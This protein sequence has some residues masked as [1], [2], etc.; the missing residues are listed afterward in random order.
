M[1]VQPCDPDQLA[2]P[3]WER[4]IGETTRAFD[5][6]TRYTEA[7][8][9]R[10]IAS[11][12]NDGEYPYDTVRDWAKR[13]RWRERAAGFDRWLA[14]RRR[15]T[16][17]DEYTEVGRRHARQAQAA[18]ELAL[19]PALVLLDRMR[20]DRTVLAELEVMPVADLYTMAMAGIRLLPH[21]Q[22]AEQSARGADPD[23]IATAVH[24]LDVEYDDDHLARVAATFAEIGLLPALPQPDPDPASEPEVIAS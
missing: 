24:I 15:Q 11:G 22:S 3:I 6:F 9:D 18:L 19:R 14:D 21:L 16:Y 7:G 17:A 12:T 20:T 13:W 1:A 10:T 4:A 8:P 5:S 2:D 23:A